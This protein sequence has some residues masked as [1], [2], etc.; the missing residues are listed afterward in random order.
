MNSPKQL[1]IKQTII[2][3]TSRKVRQSMAA[4]INECNKVIT[5]TTNNHPIRVLRKT[6]TWRVCSPFSFSQ[7]AMITADVKILFYVNDNE[8]YEIPKTTHES[9]GH[10]GAPSIL[11]SDNGREFSNNL[12]SNLK[13]MWP[14]LKIVHGKPRHSQSQGSVERANQDIENMLITW[15][16]TEKTSHWIKVGLSTS[17]L[18]KEV[19]DNLENEE[20]LLEIF[21]KNELQYDD[22]IL[23]DKDNNKIKDVIQSNNSN[24]KE[25][26]CDDPIHSNKDNSIQDTIQSNNANA[27]DNR[28]KAKQNLENQ[29]IKMKTWSDK[30]LKPAEVGATVRVPVPDVDKGRGDARNILAAVIENIP[31][32]TSHM[33]RRL[34]P[35]NTKM[36]L[37]ANLAF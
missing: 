26:P 7:Q 15:M 16:Q 6:V 27:I 36:Q 9:I 29:A 19:I 18:P 17:N 21:E 3:F 4:N 14:E 25:L 34:P 30:K 35:A 12:V 8:L 22:P 20:Q 1:N 24:V 10:G 33:F 5:K 31:Q 23:P 2:K 37:N 32:I 28:K 11:Q 13:D